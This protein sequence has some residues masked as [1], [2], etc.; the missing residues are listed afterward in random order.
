MAEEI[1]E[2]EFQ[3]QMLESIEEFIENL[4]R[5]KLY[6]NNYLTLRNA[7]HQFVFYENPDGTIYYILLT[8][9]LANN[10]D[11]TMMVV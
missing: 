1:T 9:P 6:F 4:A 11:E 3:T 10:E 5:N 2:E 8:Q 7:G